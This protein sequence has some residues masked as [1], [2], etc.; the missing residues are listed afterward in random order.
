MVP[1][2]HDAGRAP[3]VLERAM[4]AASIAAVACLVRGE[5]GP[6]L[7]VLVAAP[8]LGAAVVED[9][10]RHRLPGGLLRGA[11]LAAGSVMVVAAVAAHDLG[12]LGGPV[13]GALL[14]GAAMGA[15]W[16][17]SPG[18]T[19]FGDVRLAAV[20]GLLVGWSDATAAPLALLVGFAVAAP[21]LVAR[22]LAG[23][24]RPLPFGPF[25][26]VAVVVVASVPR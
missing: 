18:S 22:R 23:H 8:A 15:I 7:P 20:G 1:T 13:A 17:L 4:A 24:L 25:L 16:A 21:V 3:T 26:T 2:L 6:V 5:I 14:A 12:R 9:L 11:A 10:H 19:G